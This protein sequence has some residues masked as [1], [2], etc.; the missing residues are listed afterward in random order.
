MVKYMSHP[1]CEPVRFE[2]LVSGVVNAHFLA[3][4]VKL[5]CPECLVK[6]LGQI[7][8]LKSPKN[9]QVSVLRLRLSKYLPGYFETTPSGV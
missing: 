7:V 6:N 3:Y 1:V 4:N 8:L 5:H 2:K 9:F